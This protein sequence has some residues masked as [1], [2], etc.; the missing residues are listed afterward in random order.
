VAVGELHSAAYQ[1]GVMAVA[2]VVRREN[3]SGFERGRRTGENDNRTT[4]GPAGAGI[5]IDE[6]LT[7]QWKSQLI[8]PMR[9]DQTVT[10]SFDRVLHL[11][12]GDILG[13]L[14]M[15]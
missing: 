14:R 5:P 13:A 2:R 11:S 7:K 10:R 4:P 6:K 1:G 9:Y 3:R 12:K 15:L 8:G